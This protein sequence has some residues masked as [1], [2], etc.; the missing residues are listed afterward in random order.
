MP[1]APASKTWA[2]KRRGEHHEH[3]TASLN[4]AGK[5]VASCPFP[6]PQRTREPL[7]SGHTKHGY[8]LLSQFPYPGTEQCWATSLYGL[9][10]TVC[11]RRPSHRSQARQRGPMQTGPRESGC[12]EGRAGEDKLPP[13]RF[14]CWFRPHP[15]PSRC[16][17]A[18]CV[19]C[20]GHADSLGTGSSWTLDGATPRY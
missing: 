2:H 9:Q 16:Q 13:A 6:P 10:W 19:S 3:S 11:G 14:P 5:S 17:P 8:R 7:P 15:K 1:R 18:A 12:P 4:R 20:R